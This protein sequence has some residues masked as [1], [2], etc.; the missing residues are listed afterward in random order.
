[1][2]SA[3]NAGA[4]APT[5]EL[6]ELRGHVSDAKKLLSVLDDHIVFM[7]NKHQSKVQKYINPPSKAQQFFY[8][9]DPAGYFRIQQDAAF[10]L[11]RIMLPFAWPQIR[12]QDQPPLLFGINVWPTWDRVQFVDKNTGRDW[13][14][15]TNRPPPT[16]SY[17]PASP[18]PGPVVSSQTGTGVAYV[19]P[20]N[21]L[22]YVYVLDTAVVLPRGGVIQM[23][24][25]YE[26][27]GPAGGPVDFTPE[28]LSFPVNQPIVGGIPQKSLFANRISPILAGYKVYG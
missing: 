8:L 17:N 13:I 21:Q 24:P 7:E 10:V 16:G 15:G 2:R 9:A 25:V 26:Y 5:R 4:D 23:I 27:L 3:D 18:A 14:V 20:E 1:M 12:V 19:P 28:L 6:S 22:D 11:Q